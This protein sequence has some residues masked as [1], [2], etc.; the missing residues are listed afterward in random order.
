[1]SASTC[2][3]PESSQPVIFQAFG[4]N[5]GGC[6]RRS[7]QGSAP[8]ARRAS[9]LWCL[10]F[11]I[12]F[13]SAPPLVSICHLP[14]AKATQNQLTD[15]CARRSRFCSAHTAAEP[16]TPVSQQKSPTDS[17]GAERCRM[18]F[19]LTNHRHSV[20]SKIAHALRR[21]CGGWRLSPTPYCCC[22]TA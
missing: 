5:T 18:R 17:F 19:S 8:P 16:D 12:A 10:S 14:M 11:S 7:L 21:T 20:S 9:V 13:R 2:R 4:I 22:I 1:V 6:A 15:V 3:R